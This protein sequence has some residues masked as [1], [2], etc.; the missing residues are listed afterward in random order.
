MRKIAPALQLIERALPRLMELPDAHLNHGN[1]LRAAGR[2]VEAIESY[3]RAVSLDSERG[4]V[5][6]N[7]AGAL[8]DRGRLKPGQRV[9]AARGRAFCAARAGK[10][11]RPAPCVIQSNDVHI[12]PT[13]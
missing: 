13:G 12:G 4:M 8:N 7:L 2:L 5:R 9:R 11:G 3:H 1:V 6:C 10:Y